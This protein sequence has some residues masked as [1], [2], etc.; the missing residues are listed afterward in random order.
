MNL[1]WRMDGRATLRHSAMAARHIQ[2]AAH[3][4]AWQVRSQHRCTF[5][6]LVHTGIIES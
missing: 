5:F 3:G 2:V 1:S 6:S 4:D